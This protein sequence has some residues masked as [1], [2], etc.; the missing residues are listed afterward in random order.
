[1]TDQSEDLL[2]GGT[3]AAENGAGEE[4]LATGD[5]APP[6]QANAETSVDLLGFGDD[7]ATSAPSPAQQTQRSVPESSSHFDVF[8]SPPPPS[9]SSNDPPPNG[10]TDVAATAPLGQQEGQPKEDSRD[11]P[12]EN[13]EPSISEIDQSTPV[14]ET[15]VNGNIAV[16]GETQPKA[17][18]DETKVADAPALPPNENGEEK[19][20]PNDSENQ[21]E[22]KS[23]PLSQSTNGSAEVPAPTTTNELPEKDD[24]DE[25]KEKQQSSQQTPNAATTETRSEPLSSNSTSLLDSVNMEELR[26]ELEATK[27]QLDFL[28]NEQAQ[29]MQDDGA[30]LMEL[31]SKL[32]EHMSAR[33]EAENKSRLSE[34]SLETLTKTNE[35]QVQELQKYREMEENWHGQKTAQAEMENDLRE[36][37]KQISKAQEE[38][39]ALRELM[40]NLEKEVE[41][42]QQERMNQEEELKAIREQ[43]DEQ[44]RR[45]IA[46]TNRLNA[47]KKKEADKANLAEHF[48]DEMKALRDDAKQAKEQVEE[49]MAAKASLEDELSQTK[50]SSDSRTRQAEIALADEKRLNEDRKGKMKAFIEKKSEELRQAKADAESLQ[51]ELNQ[52]SRSLV[53]LNN[54]WKQLHAQW[55]QSQTRNRELQRDLNRIKKDSENLHK[56]GDTL[57]MKLSRSATETEEHKN[58]RLAAKNEL[59]TVLKTLEA[60]RDVSTRLRDAIK[61]T[62]TPKALSQQQ[63]LKENLEELE[64]ELARLS[65]RFGKPLPPVSGGGLDVSEGGVSVDEDVMGEDGKASRSDA[66]IQRLI[67]K[68]DYET[69]GVSKH[70]MALSGEIERL[71]ML[72]DVS[73]SRNCYSALSDIIL[74]SPNAAPGDNGRGGEESAIPLRAIRSHDYGQV[75]SNTAA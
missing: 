12:A 39:D 15:N 20:E 72:I 67:G 7:V 43:R 31:Q 33:A 25:E 56:V 42:L 30:L 10:G 40:F 18:D 27:A 45:E 21:T 58:K 23:P 57:E 55:V 49:L 13:P 6:P 4:N 74:G 75:P 73:G 59:M 52:T 38:N 47:A 32:Q 61:F 60:E 26:S 69:Q 66:D 19:S 44:E 51:T 3:P 17:S 8:A 34:Q 29:R 36:A 22:T 9:L 50:L 41:G 16:S 63:L 28:R 46:L 11:T 68:L 37:K 71:H 5:T 2:S 65:R 14:V 64:S 62:F 1:M 53:D 70:I 35:E 24:H 54:R 48:E